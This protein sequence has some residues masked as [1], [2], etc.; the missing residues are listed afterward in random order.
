MGRGRDPFPSPGSRQ[1][2]GQGVD[3]GANPRT[4]W[5]GAR[6]LFAPGKGGRGRAGGLLGLYVS[7]WASGPAGFGDSFRTVSIFWPL[8]QRPGPSGPS[9]SGAWRL[10]G[11]AAEAGLGLRGVGGLAGSE[12]V[13]WGVS[14]P[15]TRTR[16]GGAGL[17]SGGQAEPPDPQRPRASAAAGRVPRSAA[18]WVVAPSPEGRAS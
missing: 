17:G 11:P 10:R 13:G 3:G 8:E 2:L 16:D 6:R 1:A 4:A 7:R 12:Q 9:P 18:A 14:P 5:P 15:R